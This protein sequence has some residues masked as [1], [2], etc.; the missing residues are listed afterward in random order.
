MLVDGTTLQAEGTGIGIIIESA[1]AWR[2]VSRGT[3]RYSTHL[4][5]TGSLEEGLVILEVIIATHDLLD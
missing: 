3:T 4:W 1:L 2:A 5:A